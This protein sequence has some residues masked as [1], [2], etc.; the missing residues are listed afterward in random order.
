MIKNIT[1]LIGTA[2]IVTFCVAFSP[3]IIH[4]QNNLYKQLIG[5][6]RN[7]YVKISI[8]SKTPGGAP[9]IMDADTSNWEA[10]LNIKPIRTYF[11]QDGTYYSEYRNLKDSVVGTPSG[12]WAVVADT[13]I[14]TQLTPHKNEM[15]LHVSITKNIATFNGLIDFDGDGKVN[16]SYYGIQ[17][18]F[19]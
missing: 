2:F 16:D 12:T 13:I 5:E 1:Y 9:M 4:Q 10:R 19:K 6:W 11:N 18:K 7:L 14:M 15:H 8:P 3:G 17:Q